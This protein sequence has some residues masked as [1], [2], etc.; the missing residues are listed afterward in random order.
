M[1]ESRQ[2]RD[3]NRAKLLRRE[4]F[5]RFVDAVR[6]CGLFEFMVRAHTKTTVQILSA[7]PCPQKHIRLV[8]GE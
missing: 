6:R 5:S 2:S 4:L 8:Q 7:A 3:S 1:D